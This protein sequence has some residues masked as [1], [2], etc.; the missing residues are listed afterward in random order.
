MTK[1]EL[2][3]YF[4]LKHEIKRQQKRLE[5]LE[6]KLSR[7]NDTVGDTV[8]DY[9]RGKGIPV[10]IEGLPS[11]AFTLPVMIGLLAEEIQ[12]NIEESERA[13]IEIEKYIQDIKD[14]KLRE[15]MRS[16]FIDCLE[17]QKVGEENYISSDYARQLIREY[18]R[19]NK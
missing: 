8:R 3:R 16:R 7:Q 11:D 5:R 4:W 15:V 17:W 1:Q 12:K 10:R 18:F 14:P 6:D 19:N 13:V 2:N 9:R